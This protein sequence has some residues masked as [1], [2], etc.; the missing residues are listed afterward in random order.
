MAFLN[1]KSNKGEPNE[2][3]LRLFGK[4]DPADDYNEK[5]LF[6]SRQ[7]RVRRFS[8]RWIPNP[9]LAGRPLRMQNNI[10]RTAG[11]LPEN[12]EIP[13]FLSLRESA[14]VIFIKNDDQYPE[15]GSRRWSN[16]TTGTIASFSNDGKI[17]V[18]IDG[19]DKLVKVDTSRFE[20][21][22]LVEEIT[23]TGKKL[24]YT[25]I[26]G[27]IEQHPLRLGWAITV[28]KSQGMT[29]DA[30]ALSFNSQYFEK[31]QAYVAL[32]RVRSLEGL[33]FTN[34]LTEKAIIF[35][36][37]KVRSFLFKSEHFPFRQIAGSENEKV[38]CFN[39]LLEELGKCDI[40]HDLTQENLFDWLREIGKTPN[41]F[42]RIVAINSGNRIN[43]KKL[44]RQIQN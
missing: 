1:G 30:V 3:V 38:H 9:D 23:D 21:R 4:R 22:E 19:S 11:N 31:G 27:W 34:P 40:E 16:G 6:Q 17:N 28:H 37:G 24:Q 12:A 35:P 20:H 8:A 26:T 29:L 15:N 32:S 2:R 14:R 25:E 42:L 33:Y 5:K 41:E 39:R 10:K 43:M 18:R 7:F 44:M 13:I 36:D